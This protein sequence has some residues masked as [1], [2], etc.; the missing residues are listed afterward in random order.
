M[1]TAQPVYDYS[2]YDYS[3][4][5]SSAAAY[6]SYPG[7][8]S[9]ASYATSGAYDGYATS[10]AYSMDASTG[11]PYT[12]VD[13][14]SGY[15]T[16]AYGYP[17][18]AATTGAPSST[19]SQT[20]YASSYSS[21]PPNSSYAYDSRRTTSPPPS[22][23]SASSAHY[24]AYDYT[25]SA[26]ATTPSSNATYSP[27]KTVSTTN[28]SPSS[29][30]YSTYATSVPPPH[31]TYSIPPGSHLAGTMGPSHIYASSATDMIPRRSDYYPSS[32]M[33]HAMHYVHHQSQRIPYRLPPR[34]GYQRELDEP[35]DESALLRHVVYIT[36]LPKEI[37]NETL[38]DVFGASCGLI[39][40]VD[41]R[42]P[43]P[44][45]WVYKDRQT[46][47]GKG[48]ATITFIHP[49]S[50]QMAINYFN[51][52]ELFGR[53]I[54]VT[55][56]PRRLYNM[57]KQ[58]T[59]FNPAAPP[60]NTT[61]PISSMIKSISTNNNAVITTTMTSSTSTTTTTTATSSSTTPTTASSNIVTTANPIATI[62]SS[63]L[64]LPRQLNHSLFK[65]RQ[66]PEQQRG[67]LPTPPNS[68]VAPIMNNALL[69][70]GVRKEL[71]RIALNRG[72]STN[73]VGVR[74]K[75]Y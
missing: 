62:S 72:N 16:T 45:I 18:T 10:A 33:P 38:A 34:G 21:S 13:P 59:P 5:T 58:N 19:T 69:R 64:G 53:E 24:A 63:T 73:P 52:K 74:P 39:A 7:Y 12:T 71:P 48:E 22:S 6:S 20:G 40:P 43:K 37:Q 66:T 60:M 55:L 49:E 4:D 9:S 8:E 70:D 17:T 61:T 47:E 32:Q 51:G 23:S 36:G 50:C 1:A 2:T 11:S 65:F 29:S 68:F 67:L 56:C 44:K 31:G 28:G 57:Q 42:S 25:S 54:R 27:Y 30:V 26:Y 3:Y 15:P 14:Y 46:R 41:V 75:P 35:G